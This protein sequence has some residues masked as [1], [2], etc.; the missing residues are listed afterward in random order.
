MNVIDMGAWRRGRTGVE[1]YGWATGRAVLSSRLR[2]ALLGLVAGLLPFQIF[3][4]GV[5]AY[6]NVF[7]IACASLFLLGL[8]RAT[9]GRESLHPRTALAAMWLVPAAMSV[10]A[11]DSPEASF[12]DL[13]YPT[14]WAC[15]VFL[16]VLWNL[17]TRTDVGCLAVGLWMG[18]VAVCV[19]SLTTRYSDGRFLEA[20]QSLR[21]A[22]FFFMSEDGIPIGGD[23]WARMDRLPYDPARS[24]FGTFFK[25]DYF[26]AFLLYPFCTALASALA[27]TRRT[28]LAGGVLAVFFGA[29]IVLTLGRGA[30]MAMVASALVCVSVHAWRSGGHWRICVVIAG[31]SVSAAA[32]WFGVVP[33]GSILDLGGTVTDAPERFDLRQ[34][35]EAWELRTYLWRE[36]LGTFRQRPILGWAQPAHI[37]YARST[38]NPWSV[39]HSHSWYI[40]TLVSCGAVGLASRLLVI[41]I[42]M[43][44]SLQSYTAGVSKMVRGMGLGALCA[45]TAFLV[46]GLFNFSYVDVRNV[47][48]L[49]VVLALGLSLDRIGWAQAKGRARPQAS[50]LRRAV[51]RP[52][53]VCLVA[54]ALVVMS[55]GL[56]TFISRMTSV[57]HLSALLL[58]L[59]VV[60]TGLLSLASARG[61]GAPR[62]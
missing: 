32:L 12:S 46:D 36:G 51:G 42:A 29:N 49:S 59:A 33:V 40:E 3:L 43:R 45:I 20:L 39:V 18:G 56:S 23:T 60:T 6:L 15:V 55:F 21:V 14:I 13:L 5:T 52:A 24:S 50:A 22:Q 44:S 28:A 7:S 19:F 30:A 57:H 11:S 48:S 26:A 17:R 4:P 2:R 8:L 41:A 16:A 27:A 61:S 58:G 38:P 31:L 25:S 54:A 47:M 53:G 10:M 62:V 35:A 9:Q 37:G 1:L 34:L